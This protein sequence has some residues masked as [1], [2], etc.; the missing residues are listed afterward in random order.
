MLRT[1]V[2]S[3]DVGCRASKTTW[4]YL[5]VVLLWSGVLRY[6]G[7]VDLGRL[8][9]P[10]SACPTEGRAASSLALTQTQRL[11]PEASHRS[12]HPTDDV[13]ELFVLWILHVH[14]SVGCEDGGRRRLQGVRYLFVGTASNLHPDV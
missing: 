14:E 12:V 5:G 4:V 1:R 2:V 6:I 11:V 9:H 3:L 13:E 7:S 10:V 8:V